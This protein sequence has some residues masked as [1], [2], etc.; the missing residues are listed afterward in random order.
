MFTGIIEEVGVVK[1]A[2]HRRLD[3]KDEKVL[4]GTKLGDSIAVNGACLT[5]TSLDGDGFSVDIM[6]ETVRR[7]NLGGLHYG[8]LVNLERAMPAGG[9]FGGHF[10]QGHVDGVGTVV[11]LSPEEGAVIAR[12]SAPS[13]LMSYIVNKGFI[14]VDGVSL[15]VIDCDN[16]SFSVSLVAYTREHTTLGNRKPGDVVN[17]EVDIIA[18]YVER[19]MQRDNRGVTLDFLKEHGFLRAR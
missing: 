12:I 8:D 5:M 1:G 10:V 14:A 3:I 4:G 15:T 11:S 7:T 13:G 6:P 17:L 18:K 9:R 16:F 19:L 2:S